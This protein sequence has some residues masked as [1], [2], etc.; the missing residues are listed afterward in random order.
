[1]RL[2]TGRSLIV[3]AVGP[4]R[5]PVT[6]LKVAGL[7]GMAHWEVLP[8]GA[9]GHTI[10]SYTSGKGRTLNY[11]CEKEWLIG[12]LVVR[13]GEMKNQVVI[14]EPWGILTGRIIDADGEP[15]GEC[16]LHGVDLPDY[17]PH[18]DK[19]GRFRIEFLIPNKRYDLRIVSKGPRLG[20]FIAR[21]LKV[22]PGEKKDLHDVVIAVEGKK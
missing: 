20:G 9:W 17:S 14:L 10:M 5:N 19:D 11:L 2:E 12:E 18:T 15:W 8:T 22:G 1:M 3:I 6:D 7:E 4:D 16:E 13:G 21:G